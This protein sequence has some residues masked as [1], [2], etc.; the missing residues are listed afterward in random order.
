MT[1]VVGDKVVLTDDELKYLESFLAAGDRAGFYVAYYN[2]T[3]SKQAVQQAQICSFSETYGGVA[4][5][6]NA[7]L[8]AYY[9]DHSSTP[10]DDG[11]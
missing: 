11:I 6:A 4:Y 3:G 1:K 2:M 10:Y 9:F 5:L 7:M 8:Q